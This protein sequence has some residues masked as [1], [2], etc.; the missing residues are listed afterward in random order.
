M[1]RRQCI[2]SRLTVMRLWQRTT[3][4]QAAS[5]H[6][7]QMPSKPEQAT[8]TIQE[9][10]NVAAHSLSSRCRACHAPTHTPPKEDASSANESGGPSC[11]RNLRRTKRAH[12][13]PP[14]DALGRSK[15]S[16]CMANA[17]WFAS[18]QRR[19]HQMS[20]IIFPFPFL[21]QSGKS[22]RTKLRLAATAALDS[23]SAHTD[24]ELLEKKNQRRQPKDGVS[25]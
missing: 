1:Q 22:R 14:L 18:L 4:S 7:L 20:K 19:F 5:P 23:E 13:S 2:R 9:S 25:L 15:C 6:Q 17:V 11:R 24:K 3:H 10:Q 12:P 8:A 21:F 16:S